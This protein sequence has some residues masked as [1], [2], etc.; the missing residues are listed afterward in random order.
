[1][2]SHWFECMKNIPIVFI[3]VTVLVFSW[4]LFWWAMGVE[5]I[6]PYRLKEALRENP[7][8]F[9]LIDVRT[10][11]EYKLFH[12]DGARNHPG[13]SFHPDLSRE[14]E[15][16]KPVVVI[17]MTGHRSP[18]VAYRLKKRGFRKVYNLT[19]GMLGWLLSGGESKR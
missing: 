6:L 19:W 8:G 17:C 14:Q 16:V 18:F 2:D 1:M 7:E 5:P 10:Q 15:P 3:I 12:I 11:P 13:L 9:Y 4:D